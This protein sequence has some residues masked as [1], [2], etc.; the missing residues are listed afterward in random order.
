MSRGTA[1]AQRIVE[2]HF[3]KFVEATGVQ[4]FRFVVV[5]VT[6][7]RRKAPKVELA[8]KFADSITVLHQDAHW[9]PTGLRKIAVSADQAEE[10]ARRILSRLADA[11]FFATVDVGYMGQVETIHAFMRRKA[12]PGKLGKIVD[13]LTSSYLVLAKETRQR[14]SDEFFIQFHDAF[15]PNCSFSGKI[16]AIC[17]GA[18][19]R[20]CAG[21]VTYDNSRG[22]FLNHGIAEKHIRQEN[23]CC[24]MDCLFDLQYGLT[25]VEVTYTNGNWSVTGGNFSEDIYHKEI[26]LTS[27][28]PLPAPPLSS[29]PDE[30]D[31]Y[32][33]SGPLE[34]E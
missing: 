19:L 3:R 5:D 4:G 14:G 18:E 27:C 34:D 25:G 12:A 28:C 17:T 23:G 9:R 16:E 22:T 2:R 7:I 1:R 13:P 26:T 33:H 30:T 32:L 29:L 20:T 8:V 15:G 11:V 10:F 24:V 6:K 31:G 21:E